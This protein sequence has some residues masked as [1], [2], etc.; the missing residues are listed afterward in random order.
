ML[1]LEAAVGLLGPRQAGK[2]TLALAIAASRDAV[3]LDL[4]RRE[5]RA[6]LADPA[7]FLAS[8]ED[9]LVILDEVGHV[10]E[11]FGELRGLIDDGRRR[12]RGLSRFLILG[13]AA[14]PL[15]RQSESLAGRIGWVEL[16]PLDVLEVDD[17]EPVERLW[18]RGGLPRSYLAE[19]DADSLTIRTNLIGTVLGRDL[20]H[21]APRL[22]IET[23]DRLWAMLAHGQGTQLNLS[24]LAGSLGVSTPTVGR[25]VDLLVDLLLVRR[26]PPCL[27]NLRK[28]LVRSPRLYLRDPGL[29]HALLG[30]GDLNALLRHPV[31]GASWEGFVIETLLA[32]APPRTQASF[33]RTARGAEVDLV[34]HLPGRA[35]PWVVE[36]RH[37]AAPKLTRGF[38]SACHDLAPERAFVVHAGSRRFPLPGGAEAI[39]LRAMA[40]LLAGSA[41]P[42]GEA[43][44]G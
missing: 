23:V 1:R 33:Y 43:L 20:P 8:Q 41:A 22:P 31:V 25:Y 18:V 9:R 36:V 37:G 10:P 14:V 5:D 19:T 26:L 42:A 11:L 28:R 15:L 12:D 3:Y 44:K 34:L 38:H 32:A 21:F 2:T 30:I 6:A 7:R 13:S 16:G 4:E 27:P 17:A 29:L 35:T 39:P 40:R 24:Q